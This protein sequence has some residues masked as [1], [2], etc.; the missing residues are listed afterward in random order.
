MP[1]T[2]DL[3][4]RGGVVVTASDVFKADIGIAGGK[5]AALGTD[6][7]GNR[8]V[9]ADGLLV[10]PGGVDTHVH[11]EQPSSGPAQMCDT[12]ETG[13]ASAAA[14]GTTTVICFATQ[15]R[16][17]SLK[18]AVEDY[19]VAARRA[20]VD[21]TFHLTI[22]DPTDV[23]LRDE[24][25]TLIDSGCRSVKVFMTYDGIG[26]DD[27]QLIRTLAAARKAGALV[28]V[29]AEHHALIAYLSERLVAAG[30]TAPKYH[31]WAKPTVVEREA[32]SRIVAI[33]EV[34]DVPIQIFHVS[35][36]EPAEEIARAQARGM[37]VWGE[38]CPQYLT[39]TAED[40]DRPGFEGAKFMFGPAPRGTAE[41]EGLWRAI[42][43]GTIGVISSDH[44]P[45]RFDDPR[46][47][48][49]AGENGPFTKVP[50]GIPGLAARLP[51]IFHEGVTK[52]NIELSKF[53][54]LIATRPAKLYGL[55]PK[56]GTIAVGSDADLVLFNPRA[57]QTLTNAG[58]HHGGDYTPYEGREVTGKVIA[59]YLRGTCVFE[60][61]T[62]VGAIGGGS[63]V[64]RAPYAEIEP[65]G[66]FPIP[67][68]PVT[69]TVLEDKPKLAAE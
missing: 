34:L 43:T 36:P 15:M 19:R 42:K 55:F 67:F 29:H 13:T 5:V 37:K 35:G 12:F 30:L 2:F 49:V 40:L 51:L 32:I 53:V 52:G 6:L 61:D 57:Y 20:R 27:A 4:V 46:G 45:T 47:K 31:A 44:A 26:L 28:C 23:V 58:Q 21:Y 38:T 24:L 39:I 14:G 10:L 41:A 69:S 25:P 1:T 18:A 60:N 7:E 8:V 22:S 11:I 56:K 66:V 50:N 62:V 17:G 63:F 68:D 33:A 16:G 9:D 3:V 64:P 65:R 54:D 48:K 59:T